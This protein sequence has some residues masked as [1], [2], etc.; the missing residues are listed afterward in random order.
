VLGIIGTDGIIRVRRTGDAEFSG[1][2]IN[3][4]GVVPGSDAV[5]TDVTIS[6]GS[7]DGVRRW[8][9]AR[10]LF[11]FPLAVL[12]GLSVDEQ[13][14]SAHRETLTYLWRAGFGSALI[15]VLTG[16]LGRMSWQLGQS[17]IR[18]GESKLAHAARVEYLAYHDGLTGLP[19]RSLFSKLLGQS[20]SEA[21]R[22]DRQLAVAF[23]DL[24]RFKQIND[25]LG[26]DA[27]DQLL[28]EVSDRL[29]GCMR[30]SD[31]VARLGGDEFVALLP[32]LGDP[33][34]AASVAQQILGVF[35]KPWVRVPFEITYN[36]T[37]T[38]ADGLDILYRVKTGA[39]TQNLQ[40]QWGTATE[41][42]PGL[43]FTSSRVH[44]AL[45]A[46]TLQYGD[47]S[48]HLA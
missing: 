42:L 43:A 23:L 22:Y 34:N 26:H 15:I 7:W 6:T 12:V 21:H 16:L 9:S 30:E 36:S 39:V 35:A 33:K 20:I 13:L 25:T 41:G 14:A 46:D 40:I 19:N 47:A 45:F 29:K 11:G 28:R 18:E 44:V 1:E 48:L 38:Q 5:E 31:S 4:A 37:A 27:G 10:E 3:Y 2:A 32:D 8:T 24:D 17:R